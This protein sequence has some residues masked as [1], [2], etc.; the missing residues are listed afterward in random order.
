MKKII[1]IDDE[2]IILQ[3][4]KHLL[5]WRQHGYEV[6]LETQSPKIALDYIKKYHVDVILSDIV[7]PDMS[8][9]ELLQCVKTINPD[10][11]VVIVSS[12]SDFE[13]T[14]QALRL[15]ASDYI[16]KTNLKPE[17]VLNV[18]DA[19]DIKDLDTSSFDLKKSLSEDLL[20]Y[21]NHPDVF[22]ETNSYFRYPYYSLYFFKVDQVID[23]HIQDYLHLMIETPSAKIIILNTQDACDVK[24][25]EMVAYKLNLKHLQDLSL[26][27]E[28]YL[29]QKE[30]R[31]YHP[32]QAFELDLNF[33]WEQRPQ[34]NALDVLGHL[35]P[36]QF[37]NLI[38]QLYVYTTGTLDVHKYR[39]LEL[40][41]FFSNTLYQIMTQLEKQKIITENTSAFKLQIVHQLQNANNQFDFK[42]EMNTIL[43]NITSIIQSHLEQ[44]HADFKDQMVTYL[45][46][47]YHRN[48][49][50]NDIAQHFNFSYYYMSELFNTHFDDSFNNVLNKIRIQKAVDLLNESHLS[51]RQ[52]SIEVGYTNYSHFSKLFKKHLN[53]T[54]SEYRQE[55]L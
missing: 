13:Y 36:S 52:I 40:K 34:F 46:E 28:M 47:N 15:G 14:R 26:Y 18:L 10:I 54:P 29:S 1:I 42:N 6:V 12:H 2:Y 17:I 33:A 45:E 35:A 25:K 24:F 37:Y 38:N 31:F 39:P 7:M 20:S 21:I 4:L 16:L 53:L 9:L 5:D 23:D 8:G 30:L 11:H 49:G 32:D 51:L 48:I 3:G 27:H 55:N 41:L 19:L 44:D 43:S 22:P 50:L